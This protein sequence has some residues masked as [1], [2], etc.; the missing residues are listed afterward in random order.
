[1]NYIKP[2]ISESNSQK[3]MSFNKID[4]PAQPKVPL[5]ELSQ[6][7]VVKKPFEQEEFDRMYC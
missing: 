1:M 2:T 6:N 3:R 7:V 4:F 5:R